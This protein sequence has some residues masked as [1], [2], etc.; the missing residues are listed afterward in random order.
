MFNID[1]VVVVVVVVLSAIVQRCWRVCCCC[2]AI[3]N[4]VFL[5]KIGSNPGSFFV[6]FIN[7][8]TE[9]M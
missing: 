7:N 5:I 8:F 4:V 9:K 1:V 6:L 3:T 2:G